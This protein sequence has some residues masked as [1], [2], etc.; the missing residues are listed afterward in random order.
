MKFFNLSFVA[1][2]AIPLSGCIS[3]FPEQGPP[4]QEIF[5]QS[6]VGQGETFENHAKPKHVLSIGDPQAP[7]YLRL[8]TIALSRLEGGAR[9]LDHV[10]GTQWHGA[11]M[12]L[13]QREM[14]NHS[15]GLGVFKGVVN[16]GSPVAADLR[17]E[18]FVDDLSDD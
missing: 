3:L 17:L 1:F 8:K 6:S 12:A 14:L 13:L 10:A 5:L 15:I 2:L 9:V 11:P 18:T 16:D 7:T 4:P